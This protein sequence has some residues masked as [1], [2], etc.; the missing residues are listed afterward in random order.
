MNYH[1][2]KTKN[3]RN[4][5]T[6]FSFVLEHCANFCPKKNRLFFWKGGICMSLTRTGLNFV[7][8][9]IIV[10][11]ILKKIVSEISMQPSRRTAV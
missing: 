3:R 1:I 10:F 2:P 9:E 4:Q 5:K 8:N 11:L 6:N 7:F